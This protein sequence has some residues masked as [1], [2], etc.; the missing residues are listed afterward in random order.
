MDTW[1]SK[2]IKG[3]IDA[4]ES[5]LRIEFLV[6]Y[7]SAGSPLTM[8]I[9]SHHDFASRKRTIFF[10]PGCHRLATKH[11]A[12]P[13]DKPM[14]HDELIALAQTEAMIENLLPNEVSD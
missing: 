10:S 7:A 9:F 6:E 14:R 8:G 13:C 3:D 12:V 11:G 5:A 2:E 4:Q 1:Y